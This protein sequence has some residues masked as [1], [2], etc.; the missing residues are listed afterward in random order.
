MIRLKKYKIYELTPE[1]FKPFI[2]EEKELEFERITLANFY[3][4]AERF[5]EA[6]V[7][8]FKSKVEQQETGIFLKQ[9][10][11]IIGFSFRKDYDLEKKTKIK[12]IIPLSGKFS[13]TN[14]SRV[15]E[16][17]RGQGLFKYIISWL[18]QDSFKMGIPRMIADI[19]HDN[20]PSIKG[21]LSLGYYE[22]FR[23]Q[24]IQFFTGQNITIKY[25]K[26]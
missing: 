8:V 4:V 3:H 23:V 14:F 2:P 15:A 12:G 1:N 11:K 22:I 25:N 5:G 26:K 10:G 7:P 21:V 24:L 6:R 16:E 18:I 20:I 19:Q 13:N 17:C 9:N